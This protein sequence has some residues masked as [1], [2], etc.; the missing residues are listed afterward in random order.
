MRE[1][2]KDYTIKS[3]HIPPQPGFLVPPIPYISDEVK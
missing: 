1:W 3:I 2:D